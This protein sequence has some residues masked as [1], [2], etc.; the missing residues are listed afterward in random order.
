[1]AIT[2]GACLPSIANISGMAKFKTVNIFTDL[3]CLSLFDDHMAD[4]AIMAD[5]DAIVGSMFAIVAP[6]TAEE[7]HVPDVVRER[8]PAGAHRWEVVLAVDP[9]HLGHHL[10]DLFSL[11]GAKRREIVGV[12]LLDADLDA[13][14]GGLAAGVRRFEHEDGEVLGVREHRID[15]W[16]RS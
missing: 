1:M 2:A 5:G 11:G 14:G 15:R 4:T 7:V 10:A 12:V 9:L 8:L 3:P 16:S 13:V 6:E